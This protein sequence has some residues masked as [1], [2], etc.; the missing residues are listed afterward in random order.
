MCLSQ[1]SYSNTHQEECSYT[2]HPSLCIRTCMNSRKRRSLLSSSCVGISLFTTWNTSIRELNCV[3]TYPRFP[4]SP[5]RFSQCK[6]GFST[7]L[8]CV[9]L[10]EDAVS[11]REKHEK[12]IKKQSLF[13]TQSLI[14]MWALWVC[15]VSSELQHN[16]SE[17]QRRRIHWI[18]RRIEDRNPSLLLLIQNIKKKKKKKKNKWKKIKW[19]I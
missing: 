18:D 11:P 1:A 17:D 13:L 19:K 5:R 7:P 8:T 15:L 3:W 4:C 14:V 6:A 12:K 16:I 2:L 9:V 10:Q